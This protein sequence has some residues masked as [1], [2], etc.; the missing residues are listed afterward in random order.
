MKGPTKIADIASGNLGLRELFAHAQGLR[1]VEEKLF[2]KLGAPL[3]GNFSVAAVHH[4]GALVLIARSAVWATKLRY[5][6]PDLLTWARAV[7][8]LRSVRTVEVQVGRV[9]RP[10]SPRARA[11]G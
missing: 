5:L 10:E 3:A 4:D 6:A 7:P 9:H 11:P 1:E 2:S 8:E